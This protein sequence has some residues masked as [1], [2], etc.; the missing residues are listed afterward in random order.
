MEGLKKVAFLNKKFIESCENLDTR[1]LEPFLD[2]DIV[3]NKLPKYHFLAYL[4][5]L[6]TEVRKTEKKKLIMVEKYC[7]VCHPSTQ[8][9]E[10]YSTENPMRYKIMPYSK[11]LVEYRKNPVPVFAFAISTR[12]STVFDVEPC[13]NSWGYK[14]RRYIDVRDLRKVLYR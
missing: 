13:T 14:S 4:H 9:L 3:L 12:K 2:E 1:I 6:F 10:F 11:E 7:R 8:T 5:S